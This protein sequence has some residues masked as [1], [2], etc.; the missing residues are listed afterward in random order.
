MNLLRQVILDRAS[1]KKDKSISLTFVTSLEQT[2]QE[3]MEIDELINSHGVLYFKS[4]GNL[5]QDEVKAIE[6]THIE[7]EGKTK[8]ERLRNVLYVYYTQIPV[9][10]EPKVDYSFT[11][12]YADEME[13]I[14]EYYKSKLEP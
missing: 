5:T 3:F 9:E 4:D 12:F 7:V 1:R 6:G 10:A 8:S 13:K 11:T 2:S 14:I